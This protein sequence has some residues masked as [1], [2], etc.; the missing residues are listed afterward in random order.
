MAVLIVLTPARARCALILF[1]SPVGAVR[2]LTDNS[3]LVAC[4]R[5]RVLRGFCVEAPG[6]ASENSFECLST[7]GTNSMSVTTRDNEYHTYADYLVWSRTSG[8]ELI[9]G[10]AYV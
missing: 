4:V 8:D 7:E 2:S 9:E 3:A 5:R 10:T 6:S 1:F